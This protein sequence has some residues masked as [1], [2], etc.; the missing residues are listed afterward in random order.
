VDQ[1]T[2]DGE[3]EKKQEE[4]NVSGG[5]AEL[6][7]EINLPRRECEHKHHDD[8]IEGFV[9]PMILPPARDQRSVFS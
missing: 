8:E 7:D 2:A 1:E 4:D 5:G 6:R 3:S 9:H